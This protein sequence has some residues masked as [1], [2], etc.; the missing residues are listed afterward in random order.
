MN[1]NRWKGLQLFVNE[2]KSINQSIVNDE[3]IPTITHSKTSDLPKLGTMG[4]VVKS[5]MINECEFE[6]EYG[7]RI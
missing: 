3:E 2:T 1:K 5:S 6:L 4:R 7:E